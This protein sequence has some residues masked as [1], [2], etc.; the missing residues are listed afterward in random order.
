M[1]GIGLLAVIG[2]FAQSGSAPMTAGEIPRVWD[3]AALLSLEVPLANPA[4]SPIHISSGY[5]YRIPVRTIYKSYP[6]YHPDREPPGYMKWLTQQEPQIAVD[7][8]Q[9]KTPG[10]WI[11]AGERVFDAPITFDT[12]LFTTE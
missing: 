10:D 1:W 6:V 11:R 12:Q 4:A 2:L 7:F 8:S 5:Y 9:P 3:D